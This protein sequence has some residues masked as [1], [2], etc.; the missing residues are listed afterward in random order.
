MI[1]IHNTVCA[2]A[3]VGVA[4]ASYPVPK[5]TI[6]LNEPEQSWANAVRTVLH[7]H[8]WEHSFG[9]VFQA[10]NASLFSK[11]TDDQWQL[12]ASSIR[13]HWPDNA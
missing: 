3:F 9:P 8:G 13:T 1:A 10:H 6:D 7:T 5:V 12:L 2:A 11:L 4:L